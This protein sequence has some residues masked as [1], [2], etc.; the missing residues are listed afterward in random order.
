MSSEWVTLT[1]LQSLPVA[2]LIK[3]LLESNG[4][5]GIL[6][7]EHSSQIILQGPAVYITILVEKN[8]LDK[9]QKLLSEIELKEENDFDQ[10]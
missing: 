5:A 8:N 2:Y 10:E 4:I 1:Q 6:S 3:D 9:A 7:G